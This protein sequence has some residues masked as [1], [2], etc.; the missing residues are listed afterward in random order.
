VKLSAK[1]FSV[2]LWLFYKID[3]TTSELIPCRQGD[4]RR[5]LVQSISNTLTLHHDLFAK[6][7]ELMINSLEMVVLLELRFKIPRELLDPV[8]VASCALGLVNSVQEPRYGKCG[9]N[10]LGNP[11]VKRRDLMMRL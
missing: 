6:V 7:I 2:R 4:L 11:V 9:S 1:E 5:E 10:L 8:F 3:A